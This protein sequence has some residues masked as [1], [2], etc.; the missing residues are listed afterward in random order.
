MRTGSIAP[1]PLTSS[2]R[3]RQRTTPHSGPSANAAAAPAEQ[4]H[5][6]RG[7]RGRL[8]FERLGRERYAEALDLHRRFLRKAFE[9]HGGYEV[10]CEGDAFFVAFPTAEGAVAAAADAQQALATVEWP[11]SQELRVRM[12]I[13]SGEPM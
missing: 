3:P 9:R 12:G 2:R 5:S 8:P 7:R 4:P 10:D 13:H 11:G 6:A 1:T